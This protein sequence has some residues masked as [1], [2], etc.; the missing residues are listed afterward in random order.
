MMAL[1]LSSLIVALVSSVFLA[2]ND[3]YRSV[4]QRARV[5]DNLR[6]VTDLIASE[7][8][9]VASG[10]VITAESR[11]FV[12]RLPIVMGGV[13]HEQGNHGRVYMPG[14]SEIDHDEVAGYARQDASGKWTYDPKNWSGLHDSSGSQD[15]NECLTRNGADTVGAIDDF[16]RLVINGGTTL[17]EI[18]M[19]Y[20]EVEFKIDQSQ[21][22]PWTLAVYRG[23]TGDTLRE[24]ATGITP[25]TKF[26]YRL[27]S[28]T[29]QDVVTG[30]NMASIENIRVIT[31]AIATDSIGSIRSY[32]YEWTVGIPL[33]NHN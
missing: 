3:F 2:Q 6:V 17:G 18:I 29:Y 22:D 19:I 30:A 1:T 16:A 15:A 21:L 5:Q 27:P 8:R 12:V 7:V 10:G 13:C 20:R 9:G 32:S 4:L 23:V 31:S 11:R 26:Q 28:G 24:F 14:Y 33:R 25:D